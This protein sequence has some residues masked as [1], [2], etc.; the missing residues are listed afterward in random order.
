MLCYYR[1]MAMEGTLKSRNGRLYVLYTSDEYNAPFR[2]Y[3]WWRV[4][5]T[6]GTG[7]G[8][9]PEAGDIATSTGGGGWRTRNPST[10]RSTGSVSTGTG[11]TQAET[12]ER[13]S[14]NPP[15]AGG[16]ELRWHEGRW[17]KLMAK[18][19]V[20]AGEGKAKASKKSSTNYSTVKQHHATKKSPAQL[21]R[22]I[23]DALSQAPALAR[24]KVPL[25]VVCRTLA[26]GIKSCEWKVVGMLRGAE[27]ASRTRS[28]ESAI[29]HPSSKTVGKW[30]VSFFDEL[31]PVRD[32]QHSSVEDA[33]KQ[34]PPG[35]WKLREF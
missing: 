13:V 11:S 24:Q 4:L 2:Q 15:S 33:L 26:F 35:R 7:Y 8:E 1:A 20:P 10:H 31:G 12:V 29:V 21:Q 17:E 5:E 9:R 6:H 25:R 22:E 30:Q 34:V 18:G 32:S 3:L 28:D 16:K 14:L 19:W 27:F 23:D